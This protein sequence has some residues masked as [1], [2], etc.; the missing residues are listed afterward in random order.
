[1]EDLSTIINKVQSSEELD[2]E[3]GLLLM[4][5][6][7]LSL[8]GALADNIRKKTVGDR[9]M[10]VTNCHINY[11]N[12]CNSKCKFCAY[13]REEGQNGAFTLSMDEIMEK[14]EKASNNG[15]TEL[16]IVGSLNPGLPF[17]YYEEILIKIHEKYP[18]LSLKAYTAVEIAHLS[19]ISG[20]SVREVLLRLKK[21]G[22]T[23]LPGGG[24]EIFNEK[25]RQQVCPDKISGERWLKVMETAH[26]LGIKSNATMLYGHIET[27]EDIV[28]HILRIREL[29]KKT[30]G[31]QA[32]IPLRFHPDNTYLQKNGIVTEGPTGFDDLKTIAVA[33]LLLNGHINNIK[34]YWV[35]LGEKMS[36]I[37]LAYGAND[38]DGTVMEERITHAAGGA[39]PE[40]MPKDRLIHL[41]RNAGRIPV[42]RTSNYEI[43]REY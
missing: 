37:A 30:R 29:Q 27:H 28:D 22:L 40:Y 21:A 12:V 4:K 9:V 39:A 17:E 13:F 20:M 26:G 38:I 11:S 2:F 10:F 16:H 34:S 6:M 1:M 19:R 25:T 32:F 23:G 5:S 24:G 31:F 35:M 3:D 7:N 41:I 18:S 43:I 42:E 8:I 14:A 36:Q 15:A 33:R